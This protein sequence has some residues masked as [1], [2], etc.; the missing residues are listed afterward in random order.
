MGVSLGTTTVSLNYT[1]GNYT[2]AQYNF[3]A[4]A[5]STG[6]IK[7]WDELNNNKTGLDQIVDTLR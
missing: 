3:L 2:W 7:E 4:A 6:H 5:D 1:T